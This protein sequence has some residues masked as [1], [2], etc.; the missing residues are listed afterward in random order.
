MWSRS[1]S[2][3]YYTPEEVAGFVEEEN[4]PDEKEFVDS[5]TGFSCYVWRNKSMG[6]LCGYVAVPENHPAHGLSYHKDS[7]EIKDLLAEPEKT[8]AN[9]KIQNQIN[10][11]RVHGG[12][13][14]AGVMAGKIGHWFGFDCGHSGDYTP[15]LPTQVLGQKMPWGE[16]T[17]YKDMDYVARECASLA[18]QL[19]AI[20]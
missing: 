20:E 7:V 14:Y 12:L 3:T 4:E 18:R 1:S 16:E 10:E 8:I 2:Q 6:F 5:E 13:T 17:T 15:K 9:A 11:I 19:K